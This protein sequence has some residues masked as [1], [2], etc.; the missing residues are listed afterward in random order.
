MTGSGTAALGG[1]P[2]EPPPGWARPTDRILARLRA[3]KIDDDLLT[4]RV[5]E[6]TPAVV[7]RRARLVQRRYRS[8]VAAS[9]RRLIDAARRGEPH[10]FA[11]K[12][13]LK[14]RDV[15]ASAS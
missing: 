4:G 2:G 10:M 11:A 8:A 7:V 6:A 12:L 9:L 14:V 5:T 15:L 1:R 3:R 13:P